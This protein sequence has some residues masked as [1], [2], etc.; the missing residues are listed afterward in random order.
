MKIGATL[1]AGVFVQLKMLQVLFEFVLGF[2]D[3][4]QN[5]ITQTG[6]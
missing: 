4:K 2:M 6:L 1:G 5:K 3:N